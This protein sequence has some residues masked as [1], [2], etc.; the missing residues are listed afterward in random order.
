MNWETIVVAVGGSS[1]LFGAV[2]WMVK[3][4]ITRL[5]DKYMEHQK[6]A[7]TV[8]AAETIARLKHDLQLAATE[9]QVRYAKLYEWRAEVIAELNGL[10]VDASWAAKGLVGPEL[11]GGPSQPVKYTHTNNKMWKFYNYFDKNRIY[12][13]ELLATQIDGFTYDL[14]RELIRFNA[15]RT[16]EILDDSSED[17]EKH[18]DAM[19]RALEYFD[20]V[21][22]ETRTK[23]EAE[24]RSI[25]GVS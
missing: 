22:P 21:V 25:L 11:Q 5:I 17:W 18:Y 3:S 24:F 23:L 9:H 16:R 12:L 14:R 8:S 15:H 19:L 10:L 2:G 4:L 7:L 20:C 6:S 1:V 13:P